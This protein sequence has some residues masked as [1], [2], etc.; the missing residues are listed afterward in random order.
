MD[1]LGT[2]FQLIKAGFSQKRKTLRNSLS[3]GLAIS[4]ANAAA[5]LTEAGIDP[6][7][8]AETLSLDEW[9]M[10]AAVKQGRM[11]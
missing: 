9:S 2:F 11:I 3:A 5:L 6:Q 10:L 1:L 4:P 7:R 8:R